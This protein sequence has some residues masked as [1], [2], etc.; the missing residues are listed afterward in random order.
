[1]ADTAPPA[2]ERTPSSLSNRLPLVLQLLL[3]APLSKP[4]PALHTRVL[5]HVMKRK[6]EVKRQSEAA[7]HVSCLGL[8]VAPSPAQ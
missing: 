7:V 2:P 1:M 8:G 5:L 4:V 6:E 3:Q